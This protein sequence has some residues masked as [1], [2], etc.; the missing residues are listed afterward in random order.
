MKNKKQFLK[1][2]QQGIDL[3]YIAGLVIF[4]FVVFGHIFSE[5]LIKGF[6]NGSIT[7][8]ILFA[9]GCTVMIMVNILYEMKK[10]CEGGK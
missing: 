10:K 1:D 4:N 2:L 6:N 3:F 9:S 5:A 7:L 8:L